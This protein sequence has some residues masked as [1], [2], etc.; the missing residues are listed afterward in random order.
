MT[1][2]FQVVSVWSEEFDTRRGKHI[3]QPL[4]TLLDRTEHPLKVLVDYAP[5]DLEQKAANGSPVGRL[6]NLSATGF[7][8]MFGG[9]VRMEGAVLAWEK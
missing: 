5:T 7:R 9:R 6:V 3:V 8:V 4:W 1:G 2:K